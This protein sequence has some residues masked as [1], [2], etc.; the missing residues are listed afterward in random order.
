MNIYVCWVLRHNWLTPWSRV[1]LEKLVVTQLVKKFPAFYGTRRFITVFT[2]ARH[3]SLSWARCIQSTTF[4]PISLKSSLISSHL[5]PGLPSG[6]FSFGFSDQNFICVSYLSHMCCM[7]LPSNPRSLTCFDENWY[8]TLLLYEHC[9]VLVWI[10]FNSFKATLLKG[11]ST[12][13]RLASPS[14]WQREKFHE[15]KVQAYIE[16]IC[17]TWCNICIKISDF[18][19]TAA[20]IPMKRAPL[21]ALYKFLWVLY[22]ITEVWSSQDTTSCT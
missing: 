22:H 8:S 18:E 3:W 21:K 6:L 19:R 12:F 5:R 10:H 2:R 4:H 11:L 7:S 1:C 17:R 9:H 20:M 16:H 14:F 15:Q 13:F